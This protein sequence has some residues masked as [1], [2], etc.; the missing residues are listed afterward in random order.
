MILIVMHHYAI[1]GGFDVID[2]QFNF[3]KE[4]IRFFTFGGKLGVNLFIM[5]SGYFLIK[6]KFKKKNLLRL[7]I[8]TTF[9]SIICML[10]FL[11][12]DL[13]NNII[14][15]KLLLKSLFPI[16]YN[17]W[18]FVTTYFIMYLLSNYINYFI[19]NIGKLKLKKLITALVLIFSILPTFFRMSIEVSN[20]L[21]FILIYFIGAYIRLYLNDNQYKLCRYSLIIGIV[22]YLFSFMSCIIF[23]YIGQFIPIF[24]SYATYFSGMTTPTML[25]SCIFLFIGF[26]NLNVKYNKIINKVGSATFIVYLIHDNFFIRPYL[27][28]TLFKNSLYQNSN[29]LIFHAIGSVVI[30]YVVCTVIGILY[31][32]YVERYLEKIA[33]KLLNKL[34]KTKIHKLLYIINNDE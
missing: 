3:N 20:L 6:S 18:W 1:H 13:V 32:S 19:Y 24:T 33:I 25:L 7:W 28:E 29:F 15:L 30:V 16:C 31:N 17:M 22:I 2:M 12:N 11:K 9:F 4:V 26:K 14:F 8:T 34:K 5:I 27:W 21:W 10:P 23:D